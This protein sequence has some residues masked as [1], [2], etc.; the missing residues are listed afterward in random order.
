MRRAV[1]ARH[2]T[3]IRPA[4][5]ASAGSWSYPVTPPLG[6][7]YL[8]SA[9]LK[10]GS[11][12]E[13]IDGIGEKIDQI[14]EFGMYVIQG[15]TTDEIVNRI[16][17]GTDCIGISCMFSQ[18]WPYVRMLLHAIRERFSS[19]L[20]VIGGEHATALP[21]FCLRDCE[22][23]DLCVLGEGEETFVDVVNRIGSRQLLSETA[24]IAFIDQNGK[25]TKTRARARI[26]DVEQIPYPAWDLMP[27]EPYLETRNGHGVFRGRTMAILATRGCPYKCTFCS[28]PTMYGKTYIARSPG[29]VLDEIEH[30]MA[31]YQATNIDFY[32]LTMILKKSW[33]LEFCKEIDRRGMKF[34][35][36][37]PT[38]TRSEV[39]DA[40]I[41]P[42]L[43]KTGCRNITYAPESGDPETLD[44][45]EKRVHIPNLMNSI[46]AS[47]K[48]G[49]NLKCNIVIGFPHET[50]MNI[51]RTI[52]F[53][54]KLA[55]AGVH[56]VGIYFF[57][58]YP[59]SQ[60][61]R[62][63][64]QDGSI[65]E[66]L[67]DEYFMSLVSF[68]DPTSTRG[69][70]KHVSGKELALWRFV[71]MST[72]F[73]LSYLLRP[74]RFIQFVKNVWN[75]ESK[76]V[77]EQRVGAMIDRFRLAKKSAPAPKTVSA[78]AYS[79]LHGSTRNHRRLAS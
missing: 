24:G 42:W 41:A 25:F 44:K 36:Q 51:I 48:E 20:I 49:I 45:I 67:D 19:A 23:V 38:G 69:F 79:G 76:T 1:F 7:A 5:V 64:Q 63:L 4:I 35:W 47:L 60:L 29:D 54:W 30:Y 13:C 34:T 53:C 77:L 66:K 72:F 56:D 40:D 55:I 8:A 59:G 58:P 46:R 71:G 50:R 18:D 61:F 78:E 9:L 3:I 68:M 37:L 52:V 75:Y 6:I 74:W 28:N 14:T 21:E 22:S 73:G 2:V 27:L 17:L 70:C 11:N 65:P 57:S 10:N 33:I 12:V 62:E 39:I 16:P 43:Y 31:E 26:R 32:D 15:L